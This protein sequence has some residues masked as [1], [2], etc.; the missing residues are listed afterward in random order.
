MPKVKISEYSATANS[1]TDV[2]SINIDEGC[3]PS[4]INNAIRAIM[5]HLKDFQSG[6]N[7]DPFNGP[8]NG[9][10]GATTPSTG[11]FT[12]LS[13]SGNVTLGDSSTDTLNVGNGGLVKD[14][15]GNLGLGVTPG[16]WATAYSRKVIQ[17]GPVGSI[18]SLSAST[19]NNQTYVGSNIINDSGGTSRIY[20]DW[21]SLYLQYLGKHIWQSSS[22]QTGV[23]SMVDLMTLD[24]SGNLGI[25]ATSPVYQTQ[26]YGSGQTTSNL[27][28]AGNKGGSLLLNTPT[29]SAGDGGALLFG[30]GGTGAK[31][32][33]AIKGLL[34]DGGGNTTGALAFSTRNATADTA[35]TERMRIDS[36]G[37]LG[38]GDTTANYRLDVKG[39]T[40]NGIAY[41]DG[42]VT[43]YMGTTGSNL[44]F[45]GTLTNHPIAFLTNAEERARFD[46]SG[47]LLVGSTNSSGTIGAGFKVLG[48]RPVTV[49]ADTANTT[50]IYELYSTGAAAYR[51][52]VGMGGTVYATSTAITAIS[53]Q[54]LKENIRDLDDGLASVMALKPRKFDWKEGKGANI[55]N[56]RG[57]IAQ[58]FETVF[59]DMIDEW[60]D[61]APE[62]EEPYKAINA[63]LIPTLVKAIQEQQ[64]LITQLTAR[65]TALEGA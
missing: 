22:T 48:G 60:R 25:G 9:T 15:S 35:L 39:S 62:G 19:T 4:G 56:A 40:G 41:R 54:R 59:P 24:N 45:S 23:V 46:S 5:G 31:P 61:P 26:I 63:N 10:V 30:A 2:A 47:N 42:T 33:A 1:N 55:K 52:Y 8:V 65:I 16:A 51:F 27:T 64:A 3:A 37:N 43:A 34:V 7:G 17:F 49:N 12:T 38:I 50:T 57:F 6:T 11:A 18:N 20:A 28:D 29:V 53:D 58:E 32:F 44:M 21:C 13:A 14:A 36:N